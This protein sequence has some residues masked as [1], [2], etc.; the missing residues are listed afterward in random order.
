LWIVTMITSLTPIN[1][2]KKMN[3]AMEMK[4]E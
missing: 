2:V 1:S 4:Y 3:T